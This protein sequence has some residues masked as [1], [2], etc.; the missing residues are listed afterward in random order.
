MAPLCQLEDRY[1]VAVRKSHL[2]VTTRSDGI[3]GVDIP[4]LLKDRGVATTELEVR[5]DAL[6]KDGA[7]ALFVAVVKGDL[8]GIARGWALSRATMRNIRENLVLAFVY[9]VVGIPVWPVC[10][11]PHLDFS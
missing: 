1:R 6:R 5:A 3:A 7:T 10:C 8:A 4:A 11:I 9:N 2:E